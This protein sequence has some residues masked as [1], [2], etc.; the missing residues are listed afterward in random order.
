MS[1]S[2]PDAAHARGT[3]L[4]AG[5]DSQPIEPMPE[6]LEAA[7]PA[8]FVS[9]LHL[10]AD[11]PANVAAFLYILQGEARAVASLF[12]LGD[13][14]EYWAGD[15]DLAT[16]FNARIAAAIR[17][18]ANAGTTVF[19]MSGNRDLLAG[20]AFADAIG[21][22]LLEDPTRVRFGD[23]ADAPLLLLTHGDALCTDDHAYQAF[24]RQVRNPAWQ[25]G[26]LAQPLAT[27]KAFIASLRQQSETAK[28]EKSIEIMDVNADAVAVL[29]REHG[30]PTLIHGHTHR[31]ACHRIE[32]DHHSCTRHVL[33]DWR[34]QAC[35]LRYDGRTFT[36]ES[37]G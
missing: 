23:A 9:D 17:A 30:Y 28:A 12:I 11:E 10:A 16:P 19:F 21:A 8:L 26:F 15:D 34:G 25:T 32:V 3:A 37:Q 24:R 35:W 27:R 29:L 2:A 31:P 36:T 22:C 4:A 5:G 1:D 6:A 18:V 14:F 7:L 33:S 13:L 20:P